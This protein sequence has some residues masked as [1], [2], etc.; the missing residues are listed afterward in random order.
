LYAN[1]NKGKLPAAARWLNAS[2][3]VVYINPAASLA[4]P[5]YIEGWT[6]LGLL[7]HAKA[8]SE[9][10]IFSCPLQNERLFTYPGGWTDDTTSSYGLVRR[11]S[12]YYRV[13]GPY[14][15]IT[16]EDLRY[17][18]NVSLSKLRPPKAMTADLFGQFIFG[19]TWAHLNPYGVN[20]SFSDG[21]AEFIDVGLKEYQRASRYNNGSATGYQS[22][23]VRDPFVFAFWKAM[24]SRNF[25]ALANQWP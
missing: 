18:Q 12:Y 24:D 1:G 15:G 11:T 8:L 7:F 20:V 6:G 21:H 16:A 19:S 9:P 2:S 14:P 17:T 25:A 4:D 10:R 22:D 13:S 5:A 3:S 23:T